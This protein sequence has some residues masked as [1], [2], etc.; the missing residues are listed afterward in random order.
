VTGALGLLG[1]RSLRAHRRAILGLALVVALAGGV[2]FASVAAARRTAS[3]FPRYLRS[4]HASDVAFNV[5]ARNQDDH[6]KNIAFLMDRGGTWSLS[7]AYD[8]TYAYNPTRRWTRQH[9]MSLNGKRDGFAHQDFVRC[10]EIASM[11]R[12][13]AATILDEVSSAVAEWPQFATAARV[14]DEQIE[15]I[16]RAHRL[17]LAPR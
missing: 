4:A 7:P 2:A 15:R 13:R 10:A 8:V 3:A 17:D 1:R 11:K 9:Q 16:G 5:V 12:G 14:V 6:V